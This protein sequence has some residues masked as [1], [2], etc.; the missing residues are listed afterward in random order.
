MK[1]SNKRND[2]SSVLERRLGDAKKR[3]NVRELVL[4][5]ILTAVVVY[6]LFGVLL[7]LSIARGD[8]MSPNVKSGDLMLFC[9]VGNTYHKEDVIIMH[10]GMGD[11]YVKRVLGTEGDTVAINNKTGRLVVNGEELTE[12]NIYT[13]TYSKEQGIDFPITLAKGQLFV[14]GDNRK[15]SKD[16]REFGVIQNRQVAGKVIFTTRMW[17]KI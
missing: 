10:N 9:R 7:G 4:D 17:K 6:I 2:T 11:D 8:S 16:S 1:R 13:E 5:I 15:V 3:D 12:E 14:L